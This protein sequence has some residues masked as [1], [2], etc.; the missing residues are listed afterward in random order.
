MCGT[1]L[2]GGLLKTGMVIEGENFGSETVF[3]DTEIW[4]C[5]FPN[6]FRAG[7]GFVEKVGGGLLNTVLVIGGEALGGEVSFADTGMWRFRFPNTW[8]FS[9]GVRVLRRWGE[10]C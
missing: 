6:T 1:I 9:P 8:D 4:R 2:G 10:V 7:G 3:A 5:R